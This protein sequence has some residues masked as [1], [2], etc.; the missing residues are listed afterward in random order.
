[1]VSIFSFQRVWGECIR[2]SIY[3]N[4]AMITL[5]V[6]LRTSY[7]DQQGLDLKTITLAAN[8][9]FILPLVIVFFLGQKY[10]LQGVVTSGLNGVQLCLLRD[11]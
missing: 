2:P 10:I 3:L 6:K 5:A 1:M 7:V 11:A 4:D 9:V 8:V